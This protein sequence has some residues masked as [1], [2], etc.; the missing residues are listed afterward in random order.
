MSVTEAEPIADAELDGEKL[1]KVVRDHR[2]SE[3]ATRLVGFVWL[4]EAL[5]YLSDTM[6]QV[7]APEF[8]ATSDATVR[9]ANALLDRLEREERK[10]V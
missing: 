3:I 9:L 8:E 1:R 5:A 4:G 2:R 7:P 6:N 10:H